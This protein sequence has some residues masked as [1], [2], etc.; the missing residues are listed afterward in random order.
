MYQKVFV[1]GASGYIARHILALLI[2]QGIPVRGSVRSAKRGDETRDA[3]A[4]HLGREVSM[5]ELEFVTL[6]LTQDDGWGDALEG[7]DAL[8][9]TA[10]PF[11]MNPPKDEAALITP[12]VEG[13]LRALRAAQDAG[14]ERVILTSS[15][16]SIISQYPILP[17]Q[18]FSED[19]WSNTDSPVI[20]AYAKSKTLA[21]RAAWDFVQG[22]DLKLTVINP[23]MV[24][25]TPIGEDFGTSVA[26]IRR[27]MTGADPMTAD[28]M[29][30]VV[31]VRDVADMHVRAL[32]DDATVGERFIA[33]SAPMR[34]PDMAKLL[35]QAY[36]NR[37][38][39]TMVAPKWM[40]AIL[41]LVD[42]S[43]AQVKP[44]LGT[45]QYCD[46]AKAKRVMGMEFE[47]VEPLIL[48]T[49]AY[50]DARL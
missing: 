43:M 24:Q 22:T 4:A 36:P 28:L 49:A 23:S 34:L 50:V 13:T 17:S 35:K 3:L 46:N 27:M 12:A 32:K 38:V 21:E 5:A 29:F 47:P 11:P 15:I 45:A 48:E 8:M 2:E 41:A 33:A 18:T 20:A 30:E 7:C 9:H 42:G 10:S 40:F 1:T 14:I 44:T 39:R 26:L 19:D 6:D 25:G 37:K 16:V 31:S